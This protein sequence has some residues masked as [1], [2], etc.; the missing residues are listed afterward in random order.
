MVRKGSLPELCN[1]LDDVEERQKDLDGFAWAK[2]EYAGAEQE[3]HDLEN[4]ASAREAQ[5][6]RVGQQTSAIFSVVIGLI[7]ICVLLAMQLW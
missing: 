5:V 6:Q 3:I 7:T 2:A 1:M 4:D